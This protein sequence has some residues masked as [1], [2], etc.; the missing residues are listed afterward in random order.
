LTLGAT[1]LISQSWRQKGRQVRIGFKRN[2]GCLGEQG[3]QSAR[4]KT[5]CGAHVDNGSIRLC[6]GKS[7]EQ[8]VEFMFVSTDDF[9][10]SMGSPVA[11]RGVTHALE[12]AL[13]HLIAINA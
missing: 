11:Q 9:F 2:H 10:E 4:V 3:G 7:L 8:V 13:Q 5:F 1:A 12:R 6:D